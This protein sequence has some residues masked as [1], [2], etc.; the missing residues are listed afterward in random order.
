[1]LL[2]TP[3]GQLSTHHAMTSAPPNKQCRSVQVYV[4]I[5][6]HCSVQALYAAGQQQ[7][8][9]RQYLMTEGLQVRCGT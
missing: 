2:M 3:V 4:Q 9:Q 7:C 5:T 6:G 8:L 1:M